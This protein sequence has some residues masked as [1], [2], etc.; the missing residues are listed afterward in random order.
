MSTYDEFNNV[1]W[2]AVRMG[3]E[4][5]NKIAASGTLYI[6]RKLR[7]NAFSRV[8]CPPKP[9]TAQQCIPSDT[10]ESLYYL[11]EV[12]PDSIATKI[13]WR[14]E[15]PKSWFR[16]KKMRITFQMIS[17]K[18]FQKSEQELMSYKMPLTRII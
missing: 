18:E 6:Q 13:T 12:E 3:Q 5:L 16:G 7:E 14:S 10:D 4:G 9:V 11:E 17:S 2:S 15:P 1:F 8:I